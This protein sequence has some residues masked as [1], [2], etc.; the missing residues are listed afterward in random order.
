MKLT[1]RLRRGTDEEP[2][3]PD[4]PPP[5]PGPPRG[6]PV[7]AYVGILDG[8]TLWLAVGATPG[9]LALRDDAGRVH[10]LVSDLAEDDPAHR[11]VRADLGEILEAGGEAD[12]GGYDVVLV[13]AGGR[14]PLPVWIA[15]FPRRPT[16]VP[17]SPDGR[18]QLSL[19]RTEQGMLR[20]RRRRPA[21][22]L[23]VL[24][25]AVDDDGIRVTVP[26]TGA[27][28]LD[29]VRDDAVL[30]SY[31]L[32]REGDRSV[33]V[34]T[35]AG[36]P[37]A[38]PL[39]VLAG[40]LPLRRRANDLVGPQSAVLLPVLVDEETGRDLLQLRWSPDALLVARVVDDEEPS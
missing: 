12:E 14:A 21:A 13:P 22:A 28:R 7:A 39:R 18:W 9:I 31:P 5:P 16:R 32:A 25:L 3:A 19:A 23:E 33:A 30:A 10:P 6:S 4:G 34:L 29:L 24:G 40:D 2:P 1:T 27:D 35:E 36:L 15:P 38:G 8:R 11:S 20:I 26:A 37:P 17:P